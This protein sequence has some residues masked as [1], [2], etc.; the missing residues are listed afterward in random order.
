M[1]NVHK[2]TTQSIRKLKGKQPIVAV[3][4]YDF[5]TAHL[6][7]EAGVD[8]LLVGDSLGTTHLGFDT[9]VPVTMEMMLHHARAVARAKPRALIAIDIPFGVAHQGFDGLLQVCMR[10]V[11]EAG[12]DAVKIE[13]GA[14]MADKIAALV[15]AGIP[16]L[17]HIGLLPQQVMRLGGY[18][19]FGKTESERASLLQDAQALTRAGAFALVGEMMQAACAKEIARAID[20]PL[21]GIGSG[22]E[23][24]GQIL[25]STD[26]MG[27]QLN[28]PP[29]FVK[30]FGDVQ[31]EMQKALSGY[32]EAVR[33]KQF[34]E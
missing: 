30:V 9:T 31:G 4:A 8:L 15:A 2:T 6:A 33:N 12:V 26:L 10:C 27:I 25:V 11:Q 14:A 13:G 17:G 18:R 16:V 1:A 28:R 3:T 22:G 24:D 7:D 23:C 19:S 21:I 5:I 34:P 29:S 32:A 20:I